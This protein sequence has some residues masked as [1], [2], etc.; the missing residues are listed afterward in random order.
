MI[1]DS[2]QTRHGTTF[3]CSIGLVGVDRIS[4][5]MSAGGRLES[6]LDHLARAHQDATSLQERMSV[7]Q[8]CLFTTFPEQA[9]KRI[10]ADLLHHCKLQMYQQVKLLCFVAIEPSSAVIDCIR[11]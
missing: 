5:G 9:I 2:D 6:V 1:N 10:T 11:H 3:D 7:L 8:T 4:T